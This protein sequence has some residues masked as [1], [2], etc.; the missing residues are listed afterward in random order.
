MSP[1]VG[2]DLKL[3]MVE[4]T[5]LSNVRQSPLSKTEKK[6]REH[7][8]NYCRIRDHEAQGPRPIRPVAPTVGSG[9]QS[10]NSTFPRS[11]LFWVQTD[12]QPLSTPGFLSDF[13]DE[14]KPQAPVEETFRGYTLAGRFRLPFHKRASG[15]QRPDSACEFAVLDLLADLSRLSSALGLNHSRCTLEDVWD[16]G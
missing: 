13:P 3:K 7:E 1:S 11:T 4:N 8:G 15:Q 16:K 12:A 2:L 9:L 10:V 6:T 5:G 14:V